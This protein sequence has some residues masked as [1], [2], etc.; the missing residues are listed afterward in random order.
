MREVCVRSPPLARCTLSGDEV[1]RTVTDSAG[2]DAWSAHA[3]VAMNVRLCNLAD[4]LRDPHNLFPILA[5]CRWSC[6]LDSTGTFQNISVTIV[7]M[8][9]VEDVVHR[10]FAGNAAVP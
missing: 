7:N 5:Q 6:D 2:N 4:G 3:H 10:D 9:R 8:E 1:L